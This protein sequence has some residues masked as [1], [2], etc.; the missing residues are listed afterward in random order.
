MD[1]NLRVVR[2]FHIHSQVNLP[3]ESYRKFPGHG[4]EHRFDAFQQAEKLFSP[5]LSDGVLEFIYFD[6][7]PK[8][9]NFVRVKLRPRSRL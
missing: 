6:F 5:H 7:F 1:F 4:G 3:Y 8:L 2:S 9:S